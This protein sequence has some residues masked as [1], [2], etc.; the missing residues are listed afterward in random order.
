VEKNLEYKKLYQL[1][2]SVLVLISKA[3]NS[4]YLTGGT[5]LHRYY[6]NLRYS[7]DLDFF[8]S[9]ND[10]FYEEVREIEKIF[11]DRN[12]EYTVSVSTKD[13]RRF[14]V[15][16]KLQIDFV[17][18]RTYREGKSN[19][20]NNIRI[21]NPINILTNKLTA[22]LDRDDEK[23]I[24]DIFAIACNEKFNWNEILEIVQ[25]KACVQKEL[26]LNRIKTFPLEWLENIKQISNFEIS[27]KM[28]EQLCCD[29]EKGAENN[30]NG[31]L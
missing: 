19:I 9:N 1:M 20:I 25:K 14:M 10:L 5:A 26:L 6:Y 28:V 15:H 31:H 21:D 4:L 11:Q 24:F 2:D 12:I 3:E 23:D 13:F 8:S 18:D 29:I 22:V 30:M 16:Q 17:N 27:E 7:D